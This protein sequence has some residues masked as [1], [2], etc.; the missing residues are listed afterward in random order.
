MKKKKYNTFRLIFSYLKDEKPRLFLYVFLV[1]MTYIP[2]LLSSFFWGYA[3][4]ALVDNV[5][6]M[7]L[8]FLLLREGTH[9]LFY[10][11]LSIPRDLIYNKLE[12]KFSKNVLKDLYHKISDMPTKAFEDIG[13]GEFINRMST[14]PERVM[15]L[16]GKLIKMSCR[17]IVILVILVIAFKASF[18][19]GMEIVLFS[20]IM[21]FISY[22]FF[23]KIKK[24]QEQIKKESDAEVK[25]A[26]ENLTGIREIKAL[27]IKKNI[28]ER[29]FENIDRLF[30]NQRKIAKYEVV[31]YD[32]NNF[33]YFLL[34]ALILATS[35]YLVV[36]GKM[37]Y[38]LFIVIESYIW[39]IDDVVESISDFGI[40]YNKVRVSLR[41]IDEIVNNRLYEDETFGDINLENTK[42]IIE[43]KDVKFKYSD[44][45]EYTLKGLNLKI[46]PNK[47]IAI[48][49]RS[50][51]GK[52]TIF[53]LLLRFF[54]INEGFITLDGIEEIIYL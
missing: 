12:I 38:A 47:K 53:N 50:G 6:K 36:T 3:I 54:D 34:Q 7:F 27:G 40:N 32:L 11:V 45:E 13:V 49:G 29:L 5:F 21:G 28:E 43:F 15:E 35:G 20:V 31:Y 18:I 17:A 46:E 52:T 37:T 26:T 10:S 51:N 9:I 4:Q 22:K 23:P 25:S 44:S 33:V 8:I 1:I 39:R 42:G 41:R 2:V 16:L 48:V 24:T 19:L 30:F 14:D